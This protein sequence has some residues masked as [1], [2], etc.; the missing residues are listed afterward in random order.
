MDLKA[1]ISPSDKN[2]IKRIEAAV[3]VKG[4]E[5]KKYAL[6]KWIYRNG[7]TQPYVAR[8]MGLSPENFKRKLR[9]HA[10]FN[11]NEMWALIK[12]MHAKDAFRVIYF[13]TK[14]KRKR[15]WWQVFGRYREVEKL[16]E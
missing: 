6:K 11:K 14:R 15:V 13:P 5:L 2:F 3:S 9:D 1:N 7:Y 16:D 4:C 12:F 10:T 8:L